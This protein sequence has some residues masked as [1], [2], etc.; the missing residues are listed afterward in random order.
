MAVIRG[1]IT[2]HLY[3]NSADNYHSFEFH[4]EG[5][6]HPYRHPVITITY[7]G[8]QPPQPGYDMAIHGNWQQTEEHR[9]RFVVDRY[10][11]L[12]D[13]TAR[14]RHNIAELQKAAV[15][16]VNPMKAP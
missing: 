12:E 9:W 2:R 11:P 14:H 4:R 10:E 6:R 13:H 8:H 1:H 16:H 5:N 15:H 3:S 7:H